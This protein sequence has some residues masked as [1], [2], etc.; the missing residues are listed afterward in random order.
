MTTK[1]PDSSFLVVMGRKD[2]EE[3]THGATNVTDTTVASATGFV[4]SGVSRLVMKLRIVETH[5]L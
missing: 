5:A 2:I 3:F 1:A 4:V